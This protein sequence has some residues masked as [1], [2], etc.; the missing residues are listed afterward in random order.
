M[1]LYEI[2]KNGYLISLDNFFDFNNFNQAKETILATDD[3]REGEAIAWHICKVFNLNIETTKRIIFHEITEKAIKNAIQNPTIINLNLVYAQQ[4]RQILDLIV[5]FKITPLLWQHIIANTRNS[6]SAGRCQTPALRLVYDNYREIKESP[7]KLSFN[8]SGIFTNKNISFQLNHNHLSHEEIQTF[9]EQSKLFK[10]ILSKE[11]ERETK[12]N[13]PQP[14]TTSSLQQSANNN[15][16]ISP[17]ETMALAQ[18]LYEGGYITYMR[19]DSKV[20]SKEF[21][22]KTCIFIEDHYDKSYINIDLSKIT[23]NL[24][25]DNNGNDNAGNNNIIVKPEK[26]KSKKSTKNLS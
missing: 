17:K 19:T 13:P 8:T 11:K 24:D 22:D 26:S 7:G 2:Y 21:I 6:L 4:G 16:H 18:K 10:H 15:M 12:K 23:Q 14:F 20:Y 3:D 1:D 9:L 5:G 25:D